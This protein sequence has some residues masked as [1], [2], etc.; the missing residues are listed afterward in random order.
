MKKKNQYVYFPVLCCVTDHL[1]CDFV[2]SY[3]YLCGN[4]IRNIMYIGICTQTPIHMH[5]H[6]RSVTEVEHF[7][8][9]AVRGGLPSSL[10]L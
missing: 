7:S 2:C 5:T 3:Q 10:I 8:A 4:S 9:S 1:F 6:T